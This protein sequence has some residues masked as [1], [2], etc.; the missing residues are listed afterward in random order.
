[1]EISNRQFEAANGTRLTADGTIT[2]I[3]E[4]KLAKNLDSVQGQ[5][6]RE[7]RLVTP[8]TAEFIRNVEVILGG[9][10][11]FVITGTAAVE[12]FNGIIGAVKE[13]TENFQLTNG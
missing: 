12:D 3:N 4:T 13:F 9:G 8:T 2:T 11:V 10:S 1:M 7:P 6:L 5:N